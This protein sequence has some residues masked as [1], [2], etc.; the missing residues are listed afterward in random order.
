MAN[1]GA[2]AHDREALR[3]TDLEAFHFDFDL[4]LF[5]SQRNA[6]GFLA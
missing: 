6:S 2:R 4:P 5:H 1:L 3:V